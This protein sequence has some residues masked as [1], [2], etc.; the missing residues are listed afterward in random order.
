MS[1][2]AAFASVTTRVGAPRDITRQLI[3]VDL[4]LVDLILID[5]VLVDLVLILIVVVGESL[6]LIFLLL[7]FLPLESKSLLVLF[8]REKLVY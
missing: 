4:V 3:L 6:S 1:S 2:P 8:F 7:L 5:L